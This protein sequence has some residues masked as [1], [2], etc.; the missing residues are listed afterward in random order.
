MYH[1]MNREIQRKKP[2]FTT[3]F[4][5]QEKKQLPTENLCKNAILSGLTILFL[6]SVQQRQLN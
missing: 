5:N 4:A 3:F 6:I 1:F 2:I